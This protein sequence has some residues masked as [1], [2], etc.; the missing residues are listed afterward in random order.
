MFAS[1][2]KEE[3][4]SWGREQ[5]GTGGGGGYGYEKR[6]AYDEP[7]G[8][9]WGRECESQRG[10]GY[11]ERPAESRIRGTDQGVSR[12]I[13]GKMREYSRPVTS[14]HSSHVAY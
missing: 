10:G 14:G 6:G 9:V 1:G 13:G 3:S 4:S 7:K 12:D 8:G 5:R 11:F 2:G